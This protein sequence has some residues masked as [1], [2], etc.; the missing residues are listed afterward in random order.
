[1]TAGGTVL[2]TGATGRVGG[3]VLAQLTARGVPVRAMTR[4]PARAA[5]PDGV[6]VVAG[7]PSDAAAVAAALDGVEGVFLVLVGDVVE[8]ARGF[9]AGLAASTGGVLRRVVLLSSLSV[10]HPVAHSIRDAHCE[11][12]CV[13]SKI[14]SETTFLR[15]GPFH[16]NSFWWAESVRGTGTVRCLV[17]NR[18]GAPID[19]ADVAEI[20]VR[21]LTETGHAGASYELTGPHLLT[22]G[23]QTRIIG[24]AIGRV[25]GFETATHDEAVAAFSAAGSAP[26][27]AAGNVTALRSRQVPWGRATDTAATLLGRPPRSFR[28][29]A[30]ENASVFS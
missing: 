10:L 15:P 28:V 29:W 24:A 16:S 13:I 6:D 23:D 1:M 18:P 27:V 3:Q 26:D 12:E 30:A 2:V 22:S 7:S 11:A 5:F 14:V 8:Q 20:G 19:P 21:A 9:A 17:G 4:D 25:V